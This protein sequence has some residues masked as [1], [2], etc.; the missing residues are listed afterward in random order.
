MGPSAAERA[1]EYIYK[2]WNE[3]AS[4]PDFDGRIN[5]GELPHPGI[6]T[7]P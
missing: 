7:Q 1:N 2:K 4:S 5:F 3:Q 6:V